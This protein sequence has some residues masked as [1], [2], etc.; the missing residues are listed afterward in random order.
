MPPMRAL[1]SLL[2][3]ACAAAPAAAPRRGEGDRL[4]AGD[5]AGSFYTA[6]TR[7]NGDNSYIQLS[8]LS[9]VNFAILWNAV[10][11]TGKDE[12]A[13]A[14]HLDDENNVFIAASR[15]DKK[16]WEILLVKYDPSGKLEWDIKLPS[17]QETVP[18][19]VVTARDGTIYIG[20]TALTDGRYAARLY[21]L[22]NI[23]LEDWRRDFS[24]G[25]Q[26]YLTDM[27]VED[28]VISVAVESSRGQL[29][30]PER[31]VLRFDAQGQ[32]VDR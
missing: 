22:W 5:G 13:H 9:T 4:G 21:K 15:R 11:D 24:D 17:E 25:S 16:H 10:H 26:T 30:L 31:R 29:E 20:A 19:A 23:G 32:R 3:A 28:G 8:K 18:T 6:A 27:M 14:L 7:F 2:V 12:R 1:L